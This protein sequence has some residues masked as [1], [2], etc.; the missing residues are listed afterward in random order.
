MGDSS[1]SALCIAVLAAGLS[2]RLGRPKQLLDWRGRPLVHAMAQTA[3]ASGVGEVAVIVGHAQ[4]GVIAALS[5]LAVVPVLNPDYADGQGTSVAAAAR[6][7]IDG[8]AEALMVI[9]CD[10][11]L[12]RPQHIQQCVTAW[13]TTRAQVLI[14][15][16]AGTPTNPVIWRRDTWAELAMLSGE[17]G[18]RVLF[19]RGRVT[20][21][22]HE[23]AAPEL[24]LDVDDEADYLRVLEY[25]ATT[26]R[27]NE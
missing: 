2:R 21:V 13:Q 12:L 18:G 14:P 24:L 16:V 4:E 15:Q 26:N 9:V 11:P 10:Q 5:D 6:W 7:A 3:L 23:L 8:T 27:R 25:D 17:Q 19:Q 22:W 20:P 1:A